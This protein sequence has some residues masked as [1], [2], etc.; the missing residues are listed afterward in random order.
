LFEDRE[1]NI[2]VATSGGL[3]R[4]RELSVPTISARQGLSNENILSVLAARDGSVFLWHVRW[5]ETGGITVKSRSIGNEP[6]DRSPSPLYQQK[7][8]R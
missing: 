8:A 1:G 3:D 7:Y 2:W 6:H 4:F 5:L